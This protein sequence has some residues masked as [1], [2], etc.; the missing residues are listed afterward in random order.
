[1][2]K[3][4]KA[5]AFFAFFLVVSLG[6][7]CDSSGL[8]LQEPATGG[9]G[10]S[11]ASGG[12]L[13]A[14][15]SGVGGV[16]AGGGAGGYQNPGGHAAGGNADTGGSPATG[17]HAGASTG[18]SVAGGIMGT[19]GKAGSGGRGGTNAGGISSGGTSGTGGTTCLPV[20][21][22]AIACVFG[23]LPNPDPCGCPSCAS[24]D[25]GV[26]K[27]AA[28]DA[29]CLSLPCAYPMCQAGYTV[30]TPPCGCPICVPVDA[31]APDAVI[32][33]HVAC[34]A[35]E[36]VG[37]TV[38][39]PN[40]CGCPIC[41]PADAAAA[42][43][44]KLGCVNL[45]EC[46]C[47]LTSG[48]TAIAES[49]YCPYPHCDQSGACVC[50]GGQFIGCAPVDLATCTN[51]KARVAGLCPHLS[52]STFDTL[53]QRSDSACVTKCLNEVSSCGDVACA[54]CEACDC[55]ADG[56]SAC[57]GSCNTALGE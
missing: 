14:G 30:V 37:G 49:C 44:A 47:R 41:A 46:T 31:G 19:G 15:G 36:C 48:C 34:P 55:V 54:F 5:F 9:H 51:A 42:E 38:P 28:P 20:A 40:P 17:G 50:G 43:T 25:A 32:C 2:N 39:N 53:C 11:V 35:I 10:G 23:E 27:D 57:V 1:M 24:P 7:A 6:L 26:S 8:K 18:G 4:I 13:G 29:Q 45:D 52:G 16:A 3:G 33:P 22:P 12:M 56:F 21:C